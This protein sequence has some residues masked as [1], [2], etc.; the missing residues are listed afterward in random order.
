M[1]QKKIVGLLMIP[2]VVGS[3]GIGI[4]AASQAHADNAKQATSQT[5]DKP[6]PSDTPDVQEKTP[7][8]TDTDT[9]TNN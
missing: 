6:E 1:K 4:F 2:V 7:V 9:E 8:K 5:V 3:T